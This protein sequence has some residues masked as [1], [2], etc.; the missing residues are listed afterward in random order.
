MVG[1]PF[2]LVAFLV[3]AV[4]KICYGTVGLLYKSDLISGRGAGKVAYFIVFML[5]MAIFLGGIAV[6]RGALAS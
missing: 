2:F 4:Y 3:W 5:V 1:V 6:V